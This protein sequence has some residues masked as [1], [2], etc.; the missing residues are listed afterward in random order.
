MRKPPATPEATL[1]HRLLAF[2]VTCVPIAR[3][4][5]ATRC[6]VPR[7]TSKLAKLHSLAQSMTHT[8]HACR[9]ARLHV[10]P[11][12]RDRRDWHGGHGRRGEATVERSRR[13]LRRPGRSLVRRRLGQHQ[14]DRAA[15]CSTRQSTS[16]GLRQRRLRELVHI[17]RSSAKWLA[18]RSAFPRLFREWDTRL[19][20]S[21][22][23][24]CS[25][26]APGSGVDQLSR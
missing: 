4:V 25:D 10:V 2:F 9:C 17:S 16:E 20:Q 18:V 11:A 15:V 21:W 14:R 6:D 23:T 19:H 22:P 26:A 7:L 13:R 3:S 24:G 12:A 8:L 5:P 1:T